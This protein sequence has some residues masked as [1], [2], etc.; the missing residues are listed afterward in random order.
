MRTSDRELRRIWGELI[1]FVVVTAVVGLLTSL[2][3]D[4]Y[5]FLILIAGALAGTILYIRV[6]DWLEY[7]RARPDLA[8]PLFPG[9]RQGGLANGGGGARMGQDKEQPEDRS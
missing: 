7:R 3:G 1:W 6:S 5:S 8:R 2:F 4:R 9:R